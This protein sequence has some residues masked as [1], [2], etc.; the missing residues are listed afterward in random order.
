MARDI[1]K[2]V[3][4]WGKRVA[5][6]GLTGG[7]TIITDIDGKRTSE[8][9]DI[10]SDGGASRTKI[11]RDLLEHVAELLRERDRLVAASIKASMEVITQEP[12]TVASLRESCLHLAIDMIRKKYAAPAAEQEASNG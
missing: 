9:V 6:S 12:P 10:S 11:P 7:A 3:E 2:T 1:P 8:I 4:D 5:E